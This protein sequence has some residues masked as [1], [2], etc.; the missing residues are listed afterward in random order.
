MPENGNQGRFGIL[1]EVIR[2]ADAAGIFL[3]V[4]GVL[5]P[6]RP[7]PDETFV[8][9]TTREIVRRLTEHYSLVAAVSG[10]AAPDAAGLLGLDDVLVVGNHGMELLLAG[11]HDYLLPP[12]VIERVQ[13]ATAALELNPELK[14]LEVRIE[15]KTASVALHTR[16]VPD[17]HRAWHAVLEAAQQQAEERDLVMLPGRKVVDLR[18]AGINKGTAVLRLFQQRQLQ[19]ALYIG[20]DRTDVDA[21]RTLEAL[22]SS[23]E[24][25]TVNVAVTSDESPEELLQWADLEISFDEVPELLA[26]LSDARG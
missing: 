22:R 6:I 12:E 24:A 18:P 13:E 16:G 9:E 14:A 11:E 19:A 21:F 1:D 2:H 20:D 23:S 26:H 4:D 17:E 8:P 5:A 3:D 15:N 7:R 10:R 25:F